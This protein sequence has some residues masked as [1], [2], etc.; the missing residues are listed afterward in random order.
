MR[1]LEQHAARLAEARRRRVV[2]RLAAA[3]G[4]VPGV[5]A[6]IVAGGVRLTGRRLAARAR[7]DA[8]LRWI[9]GLLR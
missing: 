5:R 9:A 3:L 8:R 1:A 4:A 2:G 6:E 7:T